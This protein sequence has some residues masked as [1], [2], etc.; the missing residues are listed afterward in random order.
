MSHNSSRESEASVSGVVS[1]GAGSAALGHICP[2]AVL[3]VLT[4]RALCPA[5]LR[6]STQQERSDYE[7][8]GHALVNKLEVKA[9][10]T[11]SPRSNGGVDDAQE[12]REFPDL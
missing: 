9:T 6:F 1:G 8:G 11:A 7:T 2:F 3:G 4:A 12:Q 5:T 10:A